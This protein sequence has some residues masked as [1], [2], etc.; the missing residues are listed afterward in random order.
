VKPGYLASVLRMGTVFFVIYWF[1]FG[2]YLG[3]ALKIR[4]SF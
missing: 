1:S 4:T 2:E 3:Q